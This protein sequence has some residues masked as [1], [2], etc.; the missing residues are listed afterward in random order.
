MSWLRAFLRRWIG[1]GVL[2]RVIDIRDLQD[3]PPICITT[4]ASPWGLGAVLEAGGWPRAYLADEI[5]S[6]DAARLGFEI[7]S[8]RGQ[9]AAEAL[10]ILVALRVWLPTWGATRA[11]VTVRS[12]SQAALGALG[13]LGSRAP[14]VAA[15]AREVALDIAVSRYGLIVRQHVPGV[16]NVEA[17]TLSRWAEPGKLVAVPPRLRSVPR[18]EVPPRG[19]EWWLASSPLGR[20]RIGLQGP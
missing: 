5:T 17:D 7:G 9:A 11:T 3:A 19:D 16:Q 1:A 6:S 18:S 20:A 10:A 2:G 4:D 15:I 14:A 12:D 8:C 13:K